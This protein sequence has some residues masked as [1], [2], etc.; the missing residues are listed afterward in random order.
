M[1]NNNELI[2]NKDIYL[3]LNRA[4][5]Y[6]FRNDLFVGFVN[7]I[8]YLIP[9][10]LLLFFIDIAF[11][12]NQSLRV[13][14]LIFITLY[15]LY[16]LYKN[17]IHYI[18]KYFNFFKGYDNYSIALRLIADSE[19]QDKVLIYLELKEYDQAN[20]LINQALE[21]KILELKNSAAMVQ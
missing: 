15:F 8:L 18:L 11:E 17:L 10:I 14:V 16:I 4:K 13:I 2:Y 9:V 12:L 1:V 21:Q 19:I 20:I 7:S 6:L 5:N 3:Q